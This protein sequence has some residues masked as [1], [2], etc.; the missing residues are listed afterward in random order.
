MWGI[1]L[2]PVWLSLRL[3]TVT[4]AVLLALATPLAWWLAFT[5]SRTR[6]VIESVVALPLVLPPTVLGFY[7]LI[8]LGPAGPIGRLWVEVT[9]STLTFSFIGLVV[10]STIYSFPFAV[11][12]LQVA[13]E[14]VGRGPLEAAAT[15]GAGP[16]DAFVRIASPLAVRGYVSAIVLS[17]AHTLG[18]FGVVLMV[19]GNI[20][21]RTKVVSIA[22]FEDV[23]RLDYL[24][25]HVLAGG[26]LAFSFVVL[27]A[28]YLSNRRM[29]LVR[30]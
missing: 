23:E 30:A 15:L 19:G 5:R 25:A 6:A 22:V 16:L 13:F 4:V 14:A 10:A 12:P 3:A 18:E 2:G 29:P 8:L 27:L 21:G 20:P 11:Q 7:L 1:E 17:F 28:V 24:Q 26:L 9:D